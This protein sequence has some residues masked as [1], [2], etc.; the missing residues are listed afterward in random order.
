[1]EAGHGSEA[2]ATPELHRTVALPA[3]NPATAEREEVVS[4]EQKETVLKNEGEPVSK[5]FSASEDL[6]T[7]SHPTC[8]TVQPN[9]VLCGVRWNFMPSTSKVWFRAASKGILCV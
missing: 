8:L 7:P 1:M 5:G 9:R 2:A 4:K 3:E 6:R